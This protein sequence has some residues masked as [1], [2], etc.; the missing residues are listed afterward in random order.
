[1]RQTQPVAKLREKWGLRLW[2]VVTTAGCIACGGRSETTPDSREST[3]S[4][5]AN[6]TSNGNDDDESTTGKPTGLDD[7]LPLGECVAGWPLFEGDCPWLGS[8]HLCYATKEAACA[9]LCPRD[10]A[11]TCLSGLP[12]G[13]DAQTAVSC[14]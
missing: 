8:D 7:D 1:M 5:A 9:C 14:F 12:G 2:L 3:G 10:K 13:P 4:D 11:S 6:G